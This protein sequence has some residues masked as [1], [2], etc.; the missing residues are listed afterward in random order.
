MPKEEEERL[1]EAALH[2][3]DHLRAHLELAA[4]SLEILSSQLKSGAFA[5]RDSLLALAGLAETAA[6]QARQAA[7]PA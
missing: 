3:A 4:T 6:E 7:E 5:D 1:L 2:A